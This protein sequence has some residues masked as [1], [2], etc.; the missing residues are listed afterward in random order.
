[1]ILLVPPH[2]VSPPL[3][4][5]LPLLPLPPL[6]C[7]ATTVASGTGVLVTATVLFHVVQT[8]RGAETLPLRS[9]SWYT[10]SA[11]SRTWLGLLSS[12]GSA[13]VLASLLR[14]RA[15]SRRGGGGASAAAP[16]V[17]VCILHAVSFVAMC[18]V[19]TDACPGLHARLALLM[20]TLHEALLLS[21]L[22]W[23]AA[24]A[25]LAALALNEAAF[26][27]LLLCFPRAADRPAGAFLLTEWV[28]AWT[29]PAIV[30][31]V[32]SDDSQAC[33]TSVV[34]TCV[35][36]DS[37]TAHPSVRTRTW[38]AAWWPASR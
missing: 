24:G 37:G 16:E 27:S 6:L 35:T 14:R 8:V 29:A 38:R 2:R 5:L 3:L 12:M 1:M 4:P 25:V 26:L 15:P 21:I 9:V 34:A 10:R 18:A 20:G 22:W 13:V 31:A 19:P 36:T 32:W 11:A 23:R 28:G 17:V 33:R 7:A 30:C